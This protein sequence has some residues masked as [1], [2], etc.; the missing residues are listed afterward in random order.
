[1]RERGSGT[2][3]KKRR[4]PA[5][6]TKRL[7]HKLRGS[8]GRVESMRDGESET[9]ALGN[10]FFSNFN[11][12]DF[13]RLRYEYKKSASICRSDEMLMR[14]A[15]TFTRFILHA[16]AIAILKNVYAMI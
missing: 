16:L 7:L 5:R 4:A 9:D 10:F 6:V 15:F 14:D 13:F 1:M 2:A 12:G 11:K 3:R 8:N